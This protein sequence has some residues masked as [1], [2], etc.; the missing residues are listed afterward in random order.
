MVSRSVTTSGKSISTLTLPFK[1]LKNLPLTV[2]IKDEG[3]SP[4][5]ATVTCVA[6][7]RSSRLFGSVGIGGKFRGHVIKA[8]A[9]D[10]RERCRVQKSR[11]AE[12]DVAGGSERN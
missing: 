5:R 9:K 4:K 12:V 11:G 1:G 8:R 10:T 3:C 7:L 6:I 2:L